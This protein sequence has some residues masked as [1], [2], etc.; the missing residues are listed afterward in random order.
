MRSALASLTL[1]LALACGLSAVAQE[2]IKPSDTGIRSSFDAPNVVLRPKHLEG[3]PILLWMPGTNGEPSFTVPFLKTIAAQGYRVIG[4]EYDDTPAVSQIC[5]RIP[6]SNCAAAFRS[7]RVYGPNLHGG[8]SAD[9]KASPVENPV[10]ESIS[11]RLVALLHELDKRHPNEGW[12]EYLDGE[13]P[14][15][16]RIAVSGQSQGAGMAAFIAKQH[17]VPR[18]ILFSSP[19]DFQGNLRNPR[20]A[21]WLRDKSVTPL[22]RWYAVRNSR[23]PFNDALTKSYPLLGVPA[24][25]I[26]VFSLDLPPQANAANPMVYHGINIHDMRYLPEWQFLFGNVNPN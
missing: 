15:W 6:D 10:Q 1:T 24:D 9:T 18:V 7:M 11:A 19:L 8:P 17:E 4:M 25:H 22:D 26:R 13:Q 23:E 16:S 20:F 2:L 21:P 5:P 14:K 3:A 12:A